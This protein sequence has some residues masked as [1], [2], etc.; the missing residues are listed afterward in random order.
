[1]RKILGKGA[2]A[3]ITEEGAKP[4]NKK[5]GLG[6]SSPREMVSLLEKIYRGELVSKDASV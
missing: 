6:R 4:E 3:G 1:M 5:W 2:V